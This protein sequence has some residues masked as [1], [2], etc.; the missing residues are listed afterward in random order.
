MINDKKI[1]IITV[2]L[3]SEK[4]I[5]KTIESVKSQTYKYKE[6]III[7]GVSTDSTVEIIKRYSDDIYHWKSEPDQGIADAMNKGID[8]ATGDYLL[9]LNSDDYVINDTVLEKV[10][11]YMNEELDI[12]FFKV[13]FLYE[14]ERTLIS[15][16]HGLGLLT[17]FKM[18]SCHQGQFIS[19]KLLLKLG[20]FD[21][22]LKINFDYD[23]ILRAHKVGVSYKTCD[24]I[25]SV[26]RQVGISSRRDW[27]G[28]KSRY[29]EEKIVHY[30]NCSNRRM[31]YIYK[32]YWLLYIPY[33]YIRYIM[34]SINKKYI[35]N[36]TIKSLQ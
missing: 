12:Y 21:A 18:G 23:F 6:H 28:F 26:M 11:A 25:V 10:S 20:K 4:Y 29:D 13:L 22:R 17:N 34:I 27:I 5:E 33:R 19:R 7:D 15:L 36:K 3:N 16:N 31:Y 1:S 14:D 32:I 2:A 24:D 35:K 8:L 30:K 9:F